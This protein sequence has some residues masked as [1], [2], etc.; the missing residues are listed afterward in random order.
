MFQNYISMGNWFKEQYFDWNK[1][2]WYFNDIGRLA[3][4]EINID[5]VSQ[6]VVM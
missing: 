5:W 2:L 3:Q 4:G 6:A 1:Y